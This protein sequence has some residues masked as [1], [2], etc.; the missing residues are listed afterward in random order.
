MGELLNHTFASCGG[1]RS[2][3]FAALS[4]LGS[5]AGAQ[6]INLPWAGHG[7]N[8]Q[9]DGISLVAAQPLNQIRWQTPVDLAPQYS[10][11]SLL[12]HY[13]SPL[14]T[15]SNT[16]IVP[17]KTG[18]T[19]G[20]RVEARAGADGTLRWTNDSDYSLPSHS[21]VPSFNPALTPKNRVYFP[22]AGGTVLYRDTPDSATGATGRIAFYGMTNYLADTNTFNSFVKIN[23]PLTSDR[24]GN[25][26]FGFVVTG[27]TTPLLKSGLARIAPDGT[28]S[29]VAAST[30][31]SDVG[32]SKVVHNCAPGLSLDHKTLYVGV[33]QGNF[34]GG[35]LVALDSRT[36]APISRVRLKDARTPTQDALLPDDGTASPTIGPDGDVYFGVFESSPGVNHYRG[37]LLHFNQS[38][39]QTNV[40]G[41]FGW[42]DTASVVPSSLV[43]SYHGASKYLVLVKYNNYVGAGGDG[44]NKVAILDPQDTMTDPIS[45]ATVMKEVITIAGPTPD[46]EYP[47][48]PGAVREWCINTVA[49]APFTKCAIV[50]SE[51]GKVYRWD[52]STNTLIQPLVLTLGIGEAYTPTVIGVDGTVYIIANAILFA[53]GQ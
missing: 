17:V 41:A 18:P 24:Y 39:S 12:V 49:I 9:H 4:A 11:S 13:G 50:H 21:W 25:I 22:G 44:V 43:P 47:N 7:H 51:D 2:L 30:A 8:A 29:W 35:Y 53:I 5:T 33:H 37:W 40:P 26:F 46:D 42:D 6:S 52:F 48:V 32:I 1:V 36:L 19:D 38:L 14:I 31:A 34:Q 23:T 45:G 20:F 3:I 15:R 28:G 10:G 16:V 27:T